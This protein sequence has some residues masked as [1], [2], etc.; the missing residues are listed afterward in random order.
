MFLAFDA[1]AIVRAAVPFLSLLLILV[2]I[3]EFGHFLAA[4]AFGI[5]VLEFGIG[6]PPKAKTLFTKGGT[7]YSLNWLPI[8]G[9]VRLLGEEDPSDPRSLA[10]APRWQRLTVMGA[11]VAMNLVLAVFLLSVGFMIPRERSLSMAQIVEVAQGSPASEATITGEMRDGTAPVQGIQPGDL[12]IEVAGREIKNTSEMVY[13]SRLNLGETQEWIIVRA[14][15]TLTA[16]VYARWHPPADE[17]PTG[18]RIGA[19]Q[20][21]TYNENSEPISCELKYPQT[22]SEWFWPWEAF[23]KG[24]SSLVDTMVL[25]VNEI[26][27]RVGGGGG[28]SVGGEDQPAFT[29]PVGIADTTGDLIKEAGW[30]PLIEFAA[31]LSLNLAI[32][33]A[34]PIPMLDGGRMFF[35]FLEIVRGGRRISP[36]KEGLVH[37]AG[38][39]LMM[40]GVLIVTYFD[41]ARLVT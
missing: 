23:P 12:V 11:G 4:K 25:T 21:C 34:L 9:F 15:A 26:R 24:A 41:I 18:V 1:V 3:H 39:A 7:E 13:A 28:A 22:E 33:N 10:A 8:G 19:P 29:G 16:E 2:L 37:F 27:V 31:L 14:G 6:F 5:K 40:V 35:V 32:F 20:T 17:G 36:E 38:F 30:R